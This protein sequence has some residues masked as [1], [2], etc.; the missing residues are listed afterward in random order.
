LLKSGLR[1]SKK[2]VKASLASPPSVQQRL[3]SSV[4]PNLNAAGVLTE[5]L[6]ARDGNAV[7]HAFGIPAVKQET[8][9]NTNVGIVLRPASSFSLTGAEAFTPVVLRIAI[10]RRT[11][12]NLSRAQPVTEPH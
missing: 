9:K 7:T 8:S 12:S 11:R 4:W 2:A 5:T 1:F 3:Y 10:G 6:T